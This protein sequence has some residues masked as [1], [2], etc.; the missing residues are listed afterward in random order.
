MPPP[1]PAASSRPS[2]GRSQTGRA[3][4]AGRARGGS[5]RVGA[6]CA[7][8]G[9]TIAVAP[10]ASSSDVA[11]RGDELGCAAESLRRILRQRLREHRVELG[12]QRRI[13]LAH[14]RHDARDVRHRLRG[15][16][17]A[18]ERA[19]AGQQ[20]EG[21]DAERVEIARRRR[22]LALRLLGRE[23]RRG[24]E[25]RAR[26]RERAEPRGARDAEVGDVHLPVAVEQEVRRL[27]VAVD[28][29]LAVS[30]VESV[31]R[32]LEPLER[33]ARRLRA[34]RA[35]LLLERAA[36]EVLHDD[37]RALAV[38]ADVVDRDDVRIAREPG[39]GERLARE[40]LAHR[41][42][43]GVALR[44]NLHGHGA[45]ER[46]VRRPEDLAHAAPPDRLG[47]RVPLG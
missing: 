42:V 45:A 33:L 47:T 23:I 37:E 34:F 29:A 32:L 27:H 13:Q 22:P 41:R 30:R 5:G 6:V 39:H 2:R 9:A 17:V 15:D 25:H 38:L 24:A 18:L 8:A 4:R 46:R 12:R 14:R 10:A 11:Q 16:A 35:D 44:E 1:A 40:A 20:L 43:L 3:R 36:R 21:D 26:L 19:A 31:R 28:D 7:A